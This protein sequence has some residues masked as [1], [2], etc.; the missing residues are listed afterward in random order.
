MDNI[1][2]GGK[3]FE[4]IRKLGKGSF[5]NV[6][7]VNYDDELFALKIIKNP[8]KQGIVSLRELDIM[9]RL[10]HPNLAGA[11]LIVSEY[12]EKTKKK[13]LA[14]VGI[15]MQMAE[16]DLHKAMYDKN[17]ST[18][19]R[20]EILEQITEGLSFLHDCNYLH[21]DIKPANI[22]MFD[23]N[24]VA[25]LTDFGLALRMNGEKYIDYPIEIMTIT[26][27]SINILNGSRRYTIADDIWALGMTFFEVLSKGKSLFSKLK[28]EEYTRK[29]IIKIINEKLSSENIDLT[30]NAYLGKLKNKENLINLLKQMFQFDPKL[31]PNTKTILSNFF[32]S[33]NSSGKIIVPK[34]LPPIFC[35]EMIYD[36]FDVL[37][38][39]S[40]KVPI[41]LETFFL[42]VD[43]Y[44]RSLA[45]RHP[46][47]GNWRE[48]YNN[49]VFQAALSLYMAVKT[50]EPFFADPEVI[51]ELAGNLFPSKYLIIG[52][53][54]LVNAW[55]GMIYPDNLFTNS[56]TYDRLHKA[57]EISRNCHIYRKIDIVEWKILN[58]D[59][60][61]SGAKV[62]LEKWGDFL[63]FLKNSSYYDNFKD[64]TFSYISDLYNKDLLNFNK[65]EK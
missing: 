50:I 5:G 57:F 10:E 38:R 13:S 19:S 31:R 35:N 28:K 64:V 25:K 52:E 34:I 54:A 16:K 41:H 49:T 27:R 12:I 44:Q 22:L 33:Y 3:S 46:L 36:G 51:T 53:A 21:L 56:T 37:T 62:Y 48:D 58:D 11:E 55:G 63:S 61:K 24:L 40:A 39:M 59:E 1:V 26:H 9:S 20:L 29:N 45:N 65:N 4:K 14:K 18:D 8:A 17:F 30:L 6:Y 15:L 7:E 23:D 2:I 60:A 43:I 47:I 42:A 32:I